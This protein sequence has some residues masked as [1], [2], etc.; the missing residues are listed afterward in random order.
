MNNGTDKLLQKICSSTKCDAAYILNKVGRSIHLIGA[1]GVVK[2][3]EKDLNS[4][5]RLVVSGE[6]LTEIKKSK[7]Y[8]AIKK[9]NGFS[10]F[11]KEK[12]EDEERKDYSI[13][14]FSKDKLPDAKTLHSQIAS[15]LKPGKKVRPDISAPGKS[16]AKISLVDIE[17]PYL[18]TNSSLDFIEAGSLLA[19]LFKAEPKEITYQFFREAKFFDKDNNLLTFEKLPFIR[20][21]K[22]K[23]SVVN[24]QLK[25]HHDNY[26]KVFNV[27]SFLLSVEEKVISFFVDIS[28]IAALEQAFRETVSSIPS[29]LFSTSADGSEYYFITDAVRN[30]F[31]Y[32]HEEIYN[33]K[34]LILRAINEDDFHRFRGFAE[35]LRNGE[36][37]SVDY[38]M[39]DRFGKEHWV[40]HLGIPI[41]KN[42]V[43][44]R[45]V[46]MINETTDEKI[47]QLKLQNSEEK[48]RMLIDTADD[49]IFILNGFGYFS[50][51]NKN[52]AK[53]LGYIPDEMIGKHFLEFIDKEDESKIAEAFT[54]ILS[55]TEVTTFEAQFLD[56]FDKAITFEVHAKPFITD[57][58]V[59]GMIS[60]G[61]NITDRKLTEQKI[62]ELNAKLVEANRIISIERERARHKITMLEELNK[63]KNEFI[64]N[65]S[66]ELRTPL[67][68]IVGFAET[69][70]SDPDLPKDTIKEFGDIILSEGKRLTKLINDILEFSRL[71]AGEEELHKENLELLK[72]LDECSSLF[73]IQMKDKELSL[74]KEYPENEILINGDKE[75][76]AQVFNNII[77]NAVKFTHKGGR[78]SVMVHDFGKEIEIAISDT[79]I[80]IP[81]KDI[82]KLFQKFSKIYQAGAP[83][84]GAGFGLA[85]A[86]QIIELHKG[87]I[88][89]K[90]EVDQGST[91]IIRLPKL[92]HTR[93]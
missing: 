14:L 75:R 36:L 15:L 88:R 10:S 1:F 80:G 78:I 61:R 39:R 40:R 32:S 93:G 2:A 44:V 76:L 70:S 4:F 52:G 60:I 79:G 48:F 77:S 12:F 55:S 27:N 85:K 11:Y 87:V 62:R 20:A 8:N 92:Q 35:K 56:R 42:N 64:S 58:E 23:T 54:K 13:V 83:V 59:L 24:F 7:S 68:S 67:A 31:G 6:T 84:T 38:K 19:E 71:E 33:N 47:I 65:I 30:L 37:S 89:V 86:K 72:L 25:Y 9:E 91:F 18:I 66:H 53:T 73:E 49:L 81:E 82:P 5:N 43:V 90:S 3:E 51:V 74:S 26:E 69:I 34:F 22:N 50:L 41:M 45:I 28:E 16:E 29:V 21:A 17:A 57:G 63:L 46:G